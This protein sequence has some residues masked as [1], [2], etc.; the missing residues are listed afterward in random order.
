MSPETPTSVPLP[1]RT[2]GASREPPPYSYR[3]GRPR[4]PREPTLVISSSTNLFREYLPGPRT[5]G[6]PGVMARGQI[7]RPDLTV[8]TKTLKVQSVPLGVSTPKSPTGYGD[9]P[10]GRVFSLPGVTPLS[11][12]LGPKQEKKYRGTP[13]RSTR[14]GVREIGGRHVLPPRVPVSEWGGSRESEGPTSRYT[15]DRRDGR[16]NSITCADFSPTPS[17]W[18]SS[19]G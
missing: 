3:N 16:E 11:P 2:R 5:E 9:G 6:P 8:T 17:S 19:R 1:V 14:V 10:T 18:V 4:G 12:T 15:G 13:T 7:L